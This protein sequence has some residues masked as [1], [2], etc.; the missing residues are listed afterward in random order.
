MFGEGTKL[1]SEEQDMVKSEMN[2][3]ENNG[4][5]IEPGTLYLN[6]LT[7]PAVVHEIGQSSLCAFVDLVRFVI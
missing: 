4:S 3:E 5:E 7:E 1:G 2:R 6:V